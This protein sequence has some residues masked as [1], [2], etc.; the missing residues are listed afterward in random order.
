MCNHGFA[1]V[2]SVK[3]YFDDREHSDKFPT[4]SIWNEYG[5]EKVENVIIK[6]RLS[7]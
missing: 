5:N 3:T 4:A 7:I 1:H 2:L 6:A